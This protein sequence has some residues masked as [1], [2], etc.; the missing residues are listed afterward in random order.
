MWGELGSERQPRKRSHKCA[1][2]I[3]VRSFVTPMW[4]LLHVHVLI[5]VLFV[6]ESKIQNSSPSKNRKEDKVF[7]TSVQCSLERI[8]F[9]TFSQV[10]LS[11]LYKK[12]ERPS[13]PV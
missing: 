11:L 9:E 13:L 8:S 12:K 7:T 2:G 4:N 3:F 6:R 5:P 10:F 1:A